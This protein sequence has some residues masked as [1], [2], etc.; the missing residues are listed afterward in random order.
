MLSMAGVGKVVEKVRKD[1]PHLTRAEA[2]KLV[3]MKG[4]KAR[5]KKARETKKKQACEQKAK[6]QTPKRK[7]NVKAVSGSAV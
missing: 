5:A 2:I 1:E 7:G 4:T 3:I 6:S